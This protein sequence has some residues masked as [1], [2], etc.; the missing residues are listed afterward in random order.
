MSTSTILI[1]NTASGQEADYDFLPHETV[2]DL[3][4]NLLR[5][6]FLAQKG[7]GAVGGSY[8]FTLMPESRQLRSDERLADLPLT[9]KSYVEVSWTMNAGCIQIAVF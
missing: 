3:N 7:S 9:A 6:N 1:R 4:D 8:E 2:Q 5:E